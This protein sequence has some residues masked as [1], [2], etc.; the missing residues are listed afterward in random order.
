MLWKHLG[1]AVRQKLI[2]IWSAGSQRLTGIRS[3]SAIMLDAV[4]SQT[5]HFRKTLAIIYI[6]GIRSAQVT[7]I[8]GVLWRNG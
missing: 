4:T 2:G 6:L 8:Y 1:R 5:L 7:T 3:T